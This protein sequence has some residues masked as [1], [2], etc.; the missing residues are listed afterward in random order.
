MAMPIAKT[1]GIVALVFVVLNLVGVMP[2]WP[3]VAL[4]AL[5]FVV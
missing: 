5:A 3:A 2:L 4:V 1:L